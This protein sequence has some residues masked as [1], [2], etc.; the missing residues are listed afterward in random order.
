MLHNM[1]V[2]YFRMFQ[3]CAPPYVHL[4]ST[5]TQSYYV[6]VDST[7]RTVH[8]IPDSFI[9]QLR[10]A[11]LTIPFLFLSSLFPLLSGNHLFIL[12][13][14]DCLVCLFSYVCL[15]VLLVRFHT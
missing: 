6:A 10:F 4:P 11:P 8:F 13:I 2:Q 12:H 9:L 7:P 14:C 5:T 3:I 15:F 1:V